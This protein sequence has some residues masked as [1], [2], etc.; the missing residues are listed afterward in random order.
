MN[1]LQATRKRAAKGSLLQSAARAWHPYPKL[2][3][4][5]LADCIER[6]ITEHRELS[7]R[8]EAILSRARAE[9][10]FLVVETEKPKT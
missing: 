3:G 6:A 8:L 5:S 10:N 7:Y 2:R 4:K 1:A 9:E